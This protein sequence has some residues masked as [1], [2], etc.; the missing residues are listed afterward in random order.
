MM[1]EIILKKN[2]LIF[3]IISLFLSALYADEDKQAIKIASG[4]VTGVYYPTAGA[5]CRTINHN[6]PLLY[7]SVLVSNGSVSTIEYLSANPRNFALSQS[8]IAEKAYNASSPFDKDKK[9]L[10][11]RKVFTLADESMTIIV[12]GGSNIKNFSDLKNKKISFGERGNGTEIFISDIIKSYNWEKS[13]L[14]VVYINPTNLSKSLCSGEIDAII[15]TVSHPNGLVQE[16]LNNC[17]AKIISLGEKKIKDLIG[18]KPYFKRKSIAKEIYATKLPIDV[19][20]VES[21]VY[22][23]SEMPDKLVYDFTKQIFQRIHEIQTLHPV[24][25]KLEKQNMIKMDTII[26]L[27][28]GAKKY[29]AEQGWIK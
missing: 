9:F 17:D 20:S 1:K 23:T 22:T 29:F 18:N 8:D 13:D 10:S 16:S 21:A 3:F 14:E 15:Y 2:I 5:L 4:N 7:C 27:H 26:P 12:R 25:K 24:L 19:I 6:S 28:P 11:L